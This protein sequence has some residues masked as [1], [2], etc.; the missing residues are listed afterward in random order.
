[1]DYCALVISSDC[2]ATL[3]W[4]C[5][6][7][8]SL[9]NP[10][11]YCFSHSGDLLPGSQMFIMDQAPEV[12][13]LTMHASKALHSGLSSGADSKDGTVESLFST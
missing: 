11:C 3:L 5:L 1:M 10:W 8:L 13:S 2:N 9:L 7:S 4:L 6:C 12:L